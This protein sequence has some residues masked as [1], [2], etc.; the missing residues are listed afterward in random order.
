[1]FHQQRLALLYNS[2]CDSLGDAN[3]TQE[4]DK[5]A[6]SE[7]KKIGLPLSQ[8]INRTADFGNQR[9]SNIDYNTETLGKDATEK[10]QF[11]KDLREALD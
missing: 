7:K 8:C 2:L 3:S 9:F 6:M 4:G 11:N 10:M 5:T 1:M